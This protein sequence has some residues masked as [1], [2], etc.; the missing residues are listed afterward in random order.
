MIQVTCPTC[1][2]TMSAPDDKAGQT[3]KCPCGERIRILGHI[4]TK[5][6]APPVR[7]S[8]SA[9]ETASPASPS[10]ARKSGKLLWIILP[11]SGLM[12]ITIGAVLVLLLV[13]GWKDESKTKDE[14]KTEAKTDNDK[15]A[16]GQQEKPTVPAVDPDQKKILDCVESWLA[17]QKQGDMGVQYWDNF[18]RLTSLFAVRS[19]EILL[20]KGPHRIT[21]YEFEGRPSALVKVRIDS[22]TK[23]GMQVSKIW[24]LS[25]R[26][27]E[28][29]WKT[30]SM[31]G[32]NPG[33]D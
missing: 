32:Q 5:K 14:P 3:G 21:V 7:V 19:W 18:G 28:M 20:D 1:G 13:S 17:A 8:K 31:Y 22:S 16:I 23:G 15:S 33:D 29:E 6:P 25:M 26:K 24:T 10:V 9:V 12:C 4:T 2:K 11:I 30:N 27:T